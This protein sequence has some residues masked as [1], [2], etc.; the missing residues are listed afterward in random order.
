MSNSLQRMQNWFVSQCDGN[1]EHESAIT[2]ASLD[3]PG[4]SVSIDLRGTALIDK[5]FSEFKQAYDH[6]TE[7][8]FCYTRNK[9]FEARCGP[10]KLEHAI[11]I[12]LDWASP[13]DS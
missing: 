8:I 7:W 10:L 12:F 6:P 2:I 3:N 5:P 9:K 11:E 4:W 13:I 1:W